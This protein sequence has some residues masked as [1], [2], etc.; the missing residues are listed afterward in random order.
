MEERKIILGLGNTLNKDEGSGIHL[1]NALQ[2]KLGELAGVEYVDG[3]VLGL[4]LLPWVEACS[5]LLV[6]DAV[7]A[8][9][10]PGTVV[11]LE[12]DQIP[13][14]T[15]VKLS[16]HQVTFQEVLGLA[17][18]REKLPEYLHLVGVQPADISIGI[19]LSPVVQQAF[20]E[21]MKRVKTRLLLWDLL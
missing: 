9:Q 11:E 12:K 16:D 7:N 18:F 21:M 8:N 1:L 15:G 3:G 6:L 13:M 20:P 17:K 19:E 2:E 14:Y 5:H 10:P 4:N